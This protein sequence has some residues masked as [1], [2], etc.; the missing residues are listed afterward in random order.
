MVEV[1]A[2]PPTVSC[3]EVVLECMSRY[4]PA[5]RCIRDVDG[6]VLLTI[7]WEVI[8]AVMKIPEEE[9]YED[10]TICKSQGLFS[11]KKSCYRSVIARNWLLKFQKGGSTPPSPLTREHLIQEVRDIVILLHRM[12]GNQIAFYWEDWMYFFIQVFF[13]EKRYIDWAELIAEIIHEGLSCFGN[14]KFY[15]S[16]Y[17]IYCLACTRQ[18]VGLYHENWQNNMRI[19]EYY[20]HLQQHGVTEKLLKGS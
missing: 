6:K 2:F 8:T 10:W 17:L 13:G 20:P 19:Y 15:M 11:E 5:E 7:S 16:S 9:Q 1:K 18:W 4:D 12:Q 3:Q 14:K